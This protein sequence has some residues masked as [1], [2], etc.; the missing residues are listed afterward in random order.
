[1]QV[2]AVVTRADVESALAAARA[3][4]F[5]ADLPGLA[6][7]VA[8]ALMGKLAEAWDDIEAALRRG[9]ERGLAA[10]QSHLDAA[11]AKAQDLIDDAGHKARDAHAYVLGRLQA[12]VKD[13]LDAAL[14]HVKTTLRVGDQ[15]LRLVNV[16]ISQTIN[17]GGSLKAS[18][19][20]IC[21]MT[22]EGSLTLVADYADR[23]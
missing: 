17:L 18:L 6:A 19:T 23:T 22:A 13:L 12:Y 8:G 15:T 11:I 21:T 3:V 20:E 7:P 9:Y 5:D 1:M 4:R 2:V 10:A 14:A 16:Q